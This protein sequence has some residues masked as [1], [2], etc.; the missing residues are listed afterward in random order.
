MDIKSKI[1][2]ICGTNYSGL[3]NAVESLKKRISGVDSGPLN[4]IVFYS[5]EIKVV[6]L[7]EALL[8][9]SFSK[10]RI[11]IFKEFDQLSPDCRKFIFENF[12]KI[13]EGNYLVFQTGR[14]YYRLQKDKKF[15]CDDLFSLLI[16]EAQL[17]RV[18]FDKSPPS[19]ED[20]IINARKHDLATCLYC[21]ESLFKDNNKAK[22]LG[23]QLMGILISQISY[24]KGSDRKSEDF[25]H[26]WEAD[27]S[28][29]E[30]G[31]DPRLAIETLLVKLFN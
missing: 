26:L 16:K 31:V 22:V 28:I 24:H 8:L 10:N 19:V 21:V 23:P 29:K 13:I 1:F 3:K 4:S 14:D 12:N 6:D 7:G 5:K 27:R 30:K 20:F 18:G 17:I 2:L 25:N 15:T 9:V 11:V